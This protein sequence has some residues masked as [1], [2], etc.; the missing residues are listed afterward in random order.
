MTRGEILGSRYSNSRKRCSCKQ[1]SGKQDD[2]WDVFEECKKNMKSKIRHVT[3][4][5]YKELEMVRKLVNRSVR[6]TTG[7]NNYA[8]TVSSVTCDVVKLANSA[9]V[10]TVIIS[11]CKIEAIEPLLT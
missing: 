2:C 3:V 7:S 11:V 9:G 1:C 10:V 6:I 5:V 4:A 8:G